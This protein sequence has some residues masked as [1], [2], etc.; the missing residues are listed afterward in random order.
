MSCLKFGFW[1]LFNYDLTWPFI[2]HF[3]W[4]F[5]KKLY[6]QKFP[7]DQ[8]QKFILIKTFCLSI[9]L[10]IYKK[11]Y[12]DRYDSDIIMSFYLSYVNIITSLLLNNYD[13]NLWNFSLYKFYTYN[14]T[15]YLF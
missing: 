8:P 7:R 11:N 3:H 6:A 5:Q 10:Y 12:T 2:E 14:I 15:F 13:V 9:I 1:A 4:K